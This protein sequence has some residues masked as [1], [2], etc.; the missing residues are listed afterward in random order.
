MS[1]TGTVVMVRQVRLKSSFVPSRSWG[2]VWSTVCISKGVQLKSKLRHTGWNANSITLEPDRP[3]QDRTAS[4]VIAQQCS[5]RNLRIRALLFLKGKIRCAL[6]KRLFRFAFF[7]KE[8][9][10]KCEK[11]LLLCHV[12]PCHV[13]LSVRME[14][15]GYHGTDFSW[16]FIYSFIH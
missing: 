12:M 15:L 9:P 16:N 7:F 2:C 10:K 3:Q 1:S 13:W 11:R 5:S 6:Q 14:Q 8:R 4:S